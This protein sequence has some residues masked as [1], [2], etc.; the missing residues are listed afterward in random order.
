MAKLTR[1]QQFKKI[2]SNIEWDFRTTTL[3]LTLVLVTLIFVYQLGA[4]AVRETG[5]AISRGVATIQSDTEEGVHVHGEY[6]DPYDLQHVDFYPVSKSYLR[7]RTSRDFLIVKPDDTL[8]YWYYDEKPGL[9]VLNELAMVFNI[10]I[11]QITLQSY[12]TFRLPDE[13]SRDPVPYL[14][15][16]PDHLAPDLSD[17]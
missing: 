8:E 1:W 2:F 4:F 3:M 15:L 10:R 13:F 7:I 16:F 11:E 5:A 14:N 17:V 12:E 6:A 9:D